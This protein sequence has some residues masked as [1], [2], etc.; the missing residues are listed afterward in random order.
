[1]VERGGT[2]VGGIQ[3]VGEGTLVGIGLE[4]IG[5]DVGASSLERITEERITLATVGGR[6]VVEQRLSG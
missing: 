2:R 4:Q 5:W 6:L 1:M 3:V